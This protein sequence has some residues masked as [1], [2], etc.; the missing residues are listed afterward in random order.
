MALI[1]IAEYDLKKIAYAMLV[2]VATFCEKNDLRYSLSAGTLLGSVRHQGFIPWDDDVDIMMP[3]PDYERFVHTY[4]GNH[5]YYRVH[6]IENNPNYKIKSAQV[7]D[8]RTTI[9]YKNFRINNMHVFLD[10]FPIDGV[11]KSMWKRQ[12][13]FNVLKILN[14]IYCGSILTYTKSIHYADI[15]TNPAKGI[16]RTFIKY[17]AITL[18]RIF[19]TSKIV[20]LMNWLSKK[21][22][23]YN[24]SSD[25][26]V[27][28]SC[29]R[30]TNREVMPKNEF[31]RMVKFKFE[32]RD[33]NVM[34]CYDL[35][36]KNL[37]HDYMKLPPK[38]NRVTHHGF[39]AYWNNFTGGGK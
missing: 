9:D 31:E 34:G 4:N 24:R 8:M 3:R 7:Y 15:N 39:I 26:A 2:D 30:D 28:I 35:Y 13:L 29:Y 16:I 12:I 36:L 20:Y 6:S 11:P 38:E 37:Y 21:I 10:V 14:V 25:I 23:P 27:N 32:T 22:A 1:E 5:R 19:P 18:F 33:F 17:I